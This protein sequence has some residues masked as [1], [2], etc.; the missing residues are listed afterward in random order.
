MPERGRCQAVFNAAAVKEVKNL[1]IQY[2]HDTVV[3][4]EIT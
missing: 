3:A 1:R 2:A 4:C